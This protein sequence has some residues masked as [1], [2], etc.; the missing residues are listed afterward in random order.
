MLRQISI[1]TRKSFPCL[2]ECTGPLK[3][4]VPA[5]VKSLEK[6]KSEE[7]KTPFTIN[8]FQCRYVDLFYRN[9]CC[10]LYVRKISAY[11]GDSVMPICVVVRYMLVLCS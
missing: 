6:T 8:P 4:D 2:P 7:T 11:S 9:S 3:Q 1:P 5:R 10:V